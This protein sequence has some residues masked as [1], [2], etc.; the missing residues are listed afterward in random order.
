ME[1]K[2]DYNEGNS[3]EIL[4]ASLLEKVAKNVTKLNY[5][6]PTWNIFSKPSK[7]KL[8]KFKL[9]TKY[10]G[11][12]LK[13]IRTTLD[14]KKDLNYLKNLCKINNLIP[15]NNNFLFLL[16]NYKKTSENSIIL[17]KKKIAYKII[18]IRSKKVDNLKLINCSIIEHVFIK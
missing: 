6:Y 15:G 14:T 12:N 7:F 4:K 5:E 10:K 18:Q 1:R 8:T 17:I 2:S 16:N 11:Y 3:I 9:I 13:K